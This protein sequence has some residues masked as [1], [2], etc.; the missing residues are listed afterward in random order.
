MDPALF[1]DGCV[2]LLALATRLDKEICSY[3]SE[4]F[5]LATWIEFS[6]DADF[7]WFALAPTGAAGDERSLGSHYYGH[8]ENIPCFS[9]G[10]RHIAALFVLGEL[11]RCVECWDCGFKLK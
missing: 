2:F 9:H 7:L 11:C 10:G 6:L 3:R 1:F 5:S 4:L 8:A